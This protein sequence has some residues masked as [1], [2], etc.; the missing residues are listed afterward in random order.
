M[1]FTPQLR[2]LD[3]LVAKPI[4]HRGF[5]DE[6]NGHVENCESSFAAA[7]A[8][9]YS[10]ECDI[11]LTKDGQAVVFHDDD[12]D[13]VM[14]GHGR[15]KDF[16]T[17][18]LKAMSFKQGKDRVQTLAE[19]LEQVAGRTTLVIEIKSLWD[20]DFTLT[21]HALNVLAD[22]TGPHA[23]MSFDPDLVARVAATSSGTVRGITADRVIDPYYEPLPVAKRVAMR[24]MSHLPQSQPHFI[25]F[26]Y[27]QLPFQP[28]T[29][30]QAAGFPIITWT[31][32]NDA[33]A[34]QARRWC[35]QIT[36]ENFVPA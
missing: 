15:V 35:D 20:D 21:D 22:Y 9:G 34:K 1:R 2:A 13:R 5:H 7:V 17:R 3:W 12:I 27:R 11:Q 31:I 19:L 18:E 30:F 24:E 8:Q 28:I 4:A 33:Q 16:T 6:K 14:Q 36:F 29:E 10:I 32:E 25:S 23:L 26:D